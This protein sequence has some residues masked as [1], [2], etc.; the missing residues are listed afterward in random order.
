M[1]SVLSLVSL[2]DFCS[3][4]KGFKAADITQKLP[5]LLPDLEEDKE[6]ILIRIGSQISIESLYFLSITKC[7]SSVLI[8]FSLSLLNAQNPSMKQISLL[9]LCKSTVEE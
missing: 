9:I 5:V 7:N 2:F 1:N 6:I 4:S 8:K 3:G